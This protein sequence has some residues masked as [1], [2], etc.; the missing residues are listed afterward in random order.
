MIEL[1][2]GRRKT[3]H[4]NNN[5]KLLQPFV[6]AFKVGLSAPGELR[7]QFIQVL[8]GLVPTLR[9]S[10]TRESL[11]EFISNCFLSI[12]HPES[13]ADLNLIRQF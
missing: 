3:R 2:L 8:T 10:E 1:R 11:P 7:M 4:R 9:D 12:S 5:W 6:S 13:S